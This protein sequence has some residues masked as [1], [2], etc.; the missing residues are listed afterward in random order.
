M[1]VCIAEGQQEDFASLCRNSGWE[2]S[3]CCFDFSML[4]EGGAKL[5]EGPFV[6]TDELAHVIFLS[7]MEHRRL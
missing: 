6:A 1:L 7:E 2:L 5:F 4:V 3:A